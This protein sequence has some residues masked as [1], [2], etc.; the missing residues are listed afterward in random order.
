MSRPWHSASVWLSL[1]MFL[2]AWLTAVSAGYG[3]QI[4]A[5]SDW[6][7]DVLHLKNGGKIQGYIQEESSDK[8]GFWQ[9]LQKPG[10]ATVRFFSTFSRGEIES[11]ERVGETDRDTLKARVDCLAPTFEQEQMEQLQLKIVPWGGDPQGGL[12]Y[13]SD[14]FTLYSDAGDEIVRR[15]AYRLEQVYAAFPR[16]L[17][18][19][20]KGPHP[21][22]ITLFQS[23]AEYHQELT[24]A[25]RNVGNTAYYDVGRNEIFCASDLQRL[26]EELERR[27]KEHQ[28]MQARLTAQEAAWNKQYHNRVPLQLL[29]ELE[30]DR[31]RIQKANE[32][33]E[34][35]F[36]KATRMLFQ[37][38][39]HE[40][41]HAYL[42]SCVYPPKEFDVPRW[43]N[44]GLSQILENAIVEAGALRIGHVDPE[45]L[46][47]VKSALQQGELVP[48]DQLVRAEPERFLL[49]H[50]Q[51]ERLSDRLYLTSWALTFYMVFERKKLGDQE[52]E[53]YLRSLRKEDPAKALADWAGLPLD[54]LEAAFKSYVRDLRADGRRRGE[55]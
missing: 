11:I 26:R 23:L 55:G 14:Q 29:H 21:T 18:P 24:R 12:S 40:A 37:T 39:Y 47:R 36:E 31:Q 27:R 15:A 9:I 19:R 10:K 45:R 22:R 2:A 33:N 28:T 17:Q 54:E 30:S 8:I 53:G 35:T 5:G 25:G 3:Q 16:L 52:V 38:L 42:A 49:G 7:F 20:R 34:R 50:G 1:S 46:S 4:G 6:K 44:E 32:D 13:C 51:D 48:L 41:F 43:L